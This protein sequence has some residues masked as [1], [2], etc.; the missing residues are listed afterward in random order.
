MTIN[1]GASTDKFTALV[2]RSE[3]STFQVGIRYSCKNCG[4][5]GDYQRATIVPL[6]GI[7]VRTF[8]LHSP[9]TFYT[10]KAEPR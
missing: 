2:R 4:K 7:P 9:S 8:K 1:P 3:N 10:P 5:P 6:G